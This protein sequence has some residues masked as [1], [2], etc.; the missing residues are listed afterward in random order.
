MVVI[1]FRPEFLA[2]RPNRAHVTSLSLNR[3]GR[4]QALALIEHITGGKTL[5]AEVTEQIVAKTDGVPLF[6]EELTKAVLESD[7]VRAE[8]EA[9]VLAATLTPLAIPS[10]LQD[11]LM[12]RLDRL[13]PVRE[14]AQI[15]AAIGREFSYHLLEAASPDP[16]AG[17]EGRPQPTRSG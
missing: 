13:A 1:T 15:G 9:Y 11:S 3:F 5:P 6:M 7:L 8:S 12:A 4:R 14:I 17:I 16:G 2:L 10:T